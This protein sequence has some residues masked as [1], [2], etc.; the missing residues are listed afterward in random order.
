MPKAQERRCV[1]Q[2]VRGLADSLRD[3]QGLRHYAYFR[4]R[5]AVVRNDANGHRHC[6]ALLKRLQVLNEIV[7]LP[8]Q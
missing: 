4:G 3:G 5:G 2:A 7:S 1:K 6:A 8:H